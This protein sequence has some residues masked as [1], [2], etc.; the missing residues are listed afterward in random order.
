M[1][2]SNS[3]VRKRRHPTT[4]EATTDRRHGEEE[5]VMG[6]KLVNWTVEQWRNIVFSDET[7]FLVQRE[8]SRFIRKN[9]DEK[10]FI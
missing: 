3:T 9:I 6:E 2:I 5:A 10:L 8:R 7:D 1:T 4:K